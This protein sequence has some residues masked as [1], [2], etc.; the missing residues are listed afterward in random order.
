MP[1][2]II[3]SIGEILKIW[4]HKIPKLIEEEIENLNRPKTSEEI[5]S[6]ITKKNSNK[7]PGSGDFSDKKN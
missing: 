1:K 2:K 3:D 6:I 4:K 7:F 5:E